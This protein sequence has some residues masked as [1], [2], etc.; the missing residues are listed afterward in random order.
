MKTIEFVYHMVDE[1]FDFLHCISIQSLT[2]MQQSS[3]M[4]PL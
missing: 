4:K 3:D 1:L 2:Q